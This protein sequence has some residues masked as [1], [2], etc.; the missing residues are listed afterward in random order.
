VKLHSVNKGTFVW[1]LS[2]EGRTKRGAKASDG[3]PKEIRE[4]EASGRY[5]HGEKGERAVMMC[6]AKVL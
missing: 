4:K 6:M 3:P 2:T 1:D 5:Q